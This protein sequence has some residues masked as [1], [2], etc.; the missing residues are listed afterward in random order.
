LKQAGGPRTKTDENERRYARYKAA[1]DRDG[2]VCIRRF[3][4][5]DE[6]GELTRH[7]EAYIRDVAPGMADGSVIRAGPERP[8]VVRVLDNLPVDPFFDGLGRNPRWLG[9]AEVLLGS[10]VTHSSV[11]EWSPFGW[12][13]YFD[14]PPGQPSYAPPHQDNFYYRFVPNRLLA[15]WVAIDASGEENGGMRYVP[16]SHL[17]GLRPHRMGRSVA[18]F[19][20]EI[21]DF[22]PGDEEA[23]VLFELQPGDAVVHHGDTIHRSQP[24]R[25]NR[26][27][28]GF[29]MTVRAA[30]CRRDERWFARYLEKLAEHNASFGLV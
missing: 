26:H 5:P 1:F 19:S 2:V 15:I 3:L 6:L 28:R 30:A 20:Q 8:D 21:S 16:G 23:E 7:L 13:A 22:A 25:S 17:R 29:S 11:D 14:H 24:N 10:P 27:R 18:G 9:L 12:Q 4:P